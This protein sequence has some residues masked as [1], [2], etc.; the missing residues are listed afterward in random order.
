MAARSILDAD[1]ATVSRWIRSGFAWWIDELRDMVPASWRNEKRV[2]QAYV[3]YGQDGALT[4]QGSALALPVLVD[5]ALCLLRCVSLPPMSAADR[6]RL[7]QIE[8]DRLLPLP[9]TELVLGQR[10]AEAGET[11]LA[12]LPLAAARAMMERLQA[13]GITPSAVYLAV[14]GQAGIAGIELTGALSAAGLLPPRQ[15]AAARWWLVVAFLFACNLSLLVWR[16]VQSVSRLEELVSQQESAVRLARSISNRIT[17]T[18]RQAVQLVTRRERQD[19]RAALGAVTRALPAQAWVQRYTWEAGNLRISGYR[20]KDADVAAAL[21]GSG[22][23][24]DVRSADTE[25]IA[26]VPTGLPFDIT[27][28]VREAKP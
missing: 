28:A 1:M 23:F 17:G 11:E 7:V 16:D 10:T 9:S 4:V 21:R 22:R 25:A 8:A 27:A 2:L 5:P 14:P 18:Q 13:S 6:E 19:A 12:A 20:R 26:E 3:T 15:D 24:A